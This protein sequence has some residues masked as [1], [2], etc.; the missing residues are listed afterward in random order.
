MRFDG[1][2]I[3]ADWLEI[4]NLR[5][6]SNRFLKQPGP[7][8]VPGH[9]GPARSVHGAVAE[10]A[11]RRY[12]IGSYVYRWVVTFSILFFL[13]ELAE[14]VQAGN[15]EH[16]AGHRGAGVDGVLAALPHGQERPS[17]RQVT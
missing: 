2:Y 8:E 16:D 10:V 9:R 3:L 12:A 13:A 1:Y 17:T 4:P 14:A 6:R 15:V 7:G 11:V 5:E